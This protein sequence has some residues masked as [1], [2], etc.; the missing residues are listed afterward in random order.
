MPL[1][2]EVHDI[3][4]EMVGLV[5]DLVLGVLREGDPV[6]AVETHY[7]SVRVRRLPP[8]G[9]PAQH[10]SLDGEY[11]D[12]L[13]PERPLIL[14]SDSGG[15][16]RARFTIVHELGHHILAS[17]G[18]FLLDDLDQI[19]ESYGG[20]VQA[21][22]AACHQFAGRVL[23]PAEVL[24]R[25]IGEGPVEPRHILRL[26]EDSDASWEAVAIRAADHARAD[27]A[28]VLIRD[29]GH[30]SFVTANWPTFWAR[31]S[32]VKPGGPLDRALR[33]NSRGESEVFRYGLGGADAMFCDTV[34]V[35]DRFA[36][37]VISRRRNSERGLSFLE[38]VEPKW[39]E[40]VEF[41]LR[42]NVERDEDWCE[43]C[44]GRRCPECK[45]CGCQ[46]PVENPLCPGCS[47]R[48]PRKPGAR[49]CVDCEADG[50]S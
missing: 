32:P 18:A 38:E 17:D 33:H 35:D 21:E 23:V 22:E 10:C 2:F 47:L 30:V 9:I 14:Y 34:R 6:S 42:C 31:N 11:N 41:C 19:G 44:K 13:D 16:Q 26:H 39:R 29:R 27:T 48:N 40:E 20:A 50:L 45:G 24:A 15:S 43:N 12:Y 49:F 28:V 37:A 36:V 1:R 3:A 4:T 5:S 46:V 25:V 7:R 8:A